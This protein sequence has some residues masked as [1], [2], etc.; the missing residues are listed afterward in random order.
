MQMVAA[1]VANSFVQ[2]GDAFCLLDPP[3]AAF[4]FAGQITLLTCQALRR[5]L[6]RLR[7]PTQLPVLPGSMARDAHVDTYTLS[8]M[9]PT[10]RF[11]IRHFALGLNRYGPVFTAPA[12][13][14]IFHHTF[15]VAAVAV[16]QPTHLG[17]F[18]ATMGLV[19][20]AVLLAGP[21][22]SIVAALFF[23]PGG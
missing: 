4:Y 17:H 2:P 8:F 9:M 12:D 18:D 19:Q 21:S 6:E 10:T 15:D 1:H 5:L 13:G 11:D 16:P 23:K 22:E 3:G 14:D 20:L 7:T